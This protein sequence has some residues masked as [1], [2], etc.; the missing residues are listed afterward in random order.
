M[1]GFGSPAFASRWIWLLKPCTVELFIC[2]FHLF[3][4]EITDKISK[5]KKMRNKI[6]YEK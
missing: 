6:V 1:V 3:E 4:A 2:I 5:L